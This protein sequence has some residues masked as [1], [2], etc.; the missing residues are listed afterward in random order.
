MSIQAAFTIKE[1][2]ELANLPGVS[3]DPVDESL[4]PPSG[5]KLSRTPK[6]LVN[7]LQQSSRSN[8]LPQKKTFS[9]QFLRSPVEFLG[10][11][12]RLNAIKFQEN[13]FSNQDESF[14]SSAK[15]SPKR[16]QLKSESAS[17]AFR[18]IG[19]RSVPIEGMGNLGIEFDHALG[20]ISNDSFGRA[21]HV[22]TSGES[23]AHAR[24]VLPG[25]YCAGWVKRGPAGVIANTMEDAFA[26]A[27]AIASDWQKQKPFLNGGNG[28][29]NL[30]HKAA[31]KNMRPV[32]WGDWLAIDAMEKSRGKAQGKEREKFTSI[33]HMLEIVRQSP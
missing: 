4:L 7:L 26:T 5:T 25:L 18:S 14:D 13:Q 31:N 28:W 10:E 21:T 24:D 30:S 15:V 9:F 19:Y 29:D 3:F 8:S 20:I 16:G 27:E 33:P 12:G 17:L 23:V 11:N 22:P 2:R 1:V 32:S 6:R